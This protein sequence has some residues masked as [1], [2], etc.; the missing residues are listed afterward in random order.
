MRAASTVAVPLATTEARECI[1][2]GASIVDQLDGEAVAVVFDEPGE[3]LSLRC[4]EGGRER[5]DE[6][7]FLAGAGGAR[8][9]QSEDA[10]GG[11]HLREVVADLLGA[12]AG[13]EADPGAGWD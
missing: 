10:G 13:K 3:H 2:G 7:E 12:A 4:V 11:E 5:D 9:A 6:L 1:E 8:S